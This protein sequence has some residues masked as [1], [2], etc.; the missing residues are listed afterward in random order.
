MRAPLALLAAG[1]R[2][3][4]RMHRLRAAQH[5]FLRRPGARTGTGGLPRAVL[6]L[7]VAFRKWSVGMLR[8]ALGEESFGRV[9]EQRGGGAG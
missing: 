9:E 4:L 6:L 7:L 8:F 1:A 2:H 3:T 5:G